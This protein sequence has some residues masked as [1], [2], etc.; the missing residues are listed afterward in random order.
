MW[1][2]EEK[3]NE[4]SSATEEQKSEKIVKFK[5]PNMKEAIIT[6]TRTQNGV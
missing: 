1:E 2:E 6:N 3:V 4:M 5:E